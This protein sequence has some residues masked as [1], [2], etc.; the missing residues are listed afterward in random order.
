MNWALEILELDPGA[1]ERTIKRAYARLLRSNRPDDDPDAFQRLH[2][3]YQAALNWHRHQQE[4]EQDEFAWEAHMDAEPARESVALTQEAVQDVTLSGGQPRS[5]RPASTTLHGV[6]SH[7]LEEDPALEPVTAFQPVSVPLPQ[8]DVEALVARIIDAAQTL[9]DTELGPWLEQ[10]P[11]LWSI[12]GK[13]DAGAR[14]LG[15]LQQPEIAMNGASFDLIVTTFGWDEV[16]NHVDPD[17]LKALGG[18]LHAR[19]LLL[20]GNEAQLALLLLTGDGDPVSLA[21]ARRCRMRLVRPWH[22]GR[23]LLS[24]ARPSCVTRMRAMLQRLDWY[25]SELPC[26]PI[27]Q[28]QL[29]FWRGLV[30]RSRP[31][32]NHLLVGVIRSALLS[33]L[34]LLPL[35]AVYGLLA[36]SDLLAGK[37]WPSPGGL[38]TYA[39]AGM[40][41]MLLLGMGTSPWVWAG[42]RIAAS[43]PFQQLLRLRW[44]VLPGLALAGIAGYRVDPL[45][46]AVAG[47]GAAWLAFMAAMRMFPT[48]APLRPI[49]GLGLFLAA[50]FMADTLNVPYGTVCGSMALLLHV[51]TLW[52]SRRARR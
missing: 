43:R 39:A 31:G 7:T 10:C 14:L 30:D 18:T 24:A 12:R 25:G 19:W 20:A 23:A 1:D 22:R 17:M 13:S 48:L 52:W 38:V 42:S 6:P 37:G 47:V 46:S 4:F 41:I 28:H 29:R 49:G 27:D 34:W 11:E 33:C 2:Q 21:E 15:R 8:I 51:G 5:P 36:A 44:L 3:A 50:V 26:P 45:L 16:S 35:V 40:G 9:P 32:G